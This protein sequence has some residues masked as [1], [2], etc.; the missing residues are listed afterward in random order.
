MLSA[1]AAVS[2]RPWWPGPSRKGKDAA[3]SGRGQLTRS[4][5]GMARAEF[6]SECHR[7]SQECFEQ[8]REVTLYMFFKGQFENLQQIF[9]RFSQ[10][11]NEKDH[12]DH[13]I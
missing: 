10:E 11:F 8:G 1:R 13:E 7:K 2:R 12:S 9:H 3:G 6:S 5:G 4:H